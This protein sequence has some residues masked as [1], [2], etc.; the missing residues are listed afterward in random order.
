MNLLEEFFRPANIFVWHPERAAMVSFG[1]LLL[2]FIIL[3]AKGIKIY[4]LA[5]AGIFWT[6]SALWE[7][8][9]TVRRWDVRVDLIFLWPFLALLTGIAFAGTLFSLYNHAKEKV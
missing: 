9:A 3:K 6:A 2:Y 8:W 5:L 4:S 1:I 7:I